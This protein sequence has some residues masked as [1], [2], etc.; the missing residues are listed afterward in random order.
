MKTKLS[1][2]SLALL[3]IATA[4]FG[5]V[6]YFSKSF[7]STGNTVQA[8]KFNVNAVNESGET[9][10]DGQF[11]LGENFYPGMDPVKVYA[12]EIQKNDTE[13][14]VTYQ[15][16]L[17]P[18]GKLFPA[19][20]NSPIVLS[21]ERKVNGEWK[22]IDHTSTFKPTVDN[23]QFRIFARWPHGDNDINFQGKTGNLKLKVV[24]TQVDEEEGPPFYT[25]SIAFKATP[26][27]DIRTT[28]NKEVKFYKNDQGNKVIEVKMGD[29][30]GEFEKKVGNFTI[31][32]SQEGGNTWYKVVTD[33]EYYAGPKVWKLTADRVNTSQAGVIDF[34]K[35][36]NVYL[37][38][39]SQQLYK[40]FTGNK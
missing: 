20:G 24:A 1:L 9:I 19:N 12:F 22:E 27:G 40:W 34:R 23:E 31:T 2:S 32:E 33:H 17:I 6:A 10:G 25:G 26:S 28:A 5:T 16:D 15:V 35:D 30:N 37:T 39:E 3:L 8:A 7:T 38:I 4:I 13:V 29:G 36:T 21:L 18:S 11:S 14:P